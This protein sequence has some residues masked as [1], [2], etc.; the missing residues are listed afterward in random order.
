MSCD[1]EDDDAHVRI[2]ERVFSLS[3]V[4][5][6]L[7]FSELARAQTERAE[8]ALCDAR[9]RVENARAVLLDADPND[10]LA[11]RAAQQAFDVAA[12]SV[13]RLSVQAGQTLDHLMCTTTTLEGAIRL[14]SLNASN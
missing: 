4:L 2:R 5:L 3:T 11:L 13:V 10:I 8:G 14:Y 9:E 6:A 12:R 1:G 7:R